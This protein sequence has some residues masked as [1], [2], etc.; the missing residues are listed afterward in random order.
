M[1]I[2][3]QILFGEAIQYDVVRIKKKYKF[4]NY[5]KNNN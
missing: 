2:E 1:A 5:N 3:I 4:Q